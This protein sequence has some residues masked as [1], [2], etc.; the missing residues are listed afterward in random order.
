MPDIGDELIY[1]LRDYSTSEHV[2][3]IEI[4]SRKKTPRYVV[5]FLAS[6]KAGV[7]EN[8][9]RGRLR[10][11]WSDVVAYD[12][13]MANW[14]R[15]DQTEL[16][17]PEQSAVAQVFELLIPEDVAECEWSPVRDS[18]RIHKREELQALIGI[19][20]DDLLA[21]AEGFEL[22]GDVM[23]SVDG[24]LAVAE[25]ACRINPM[26]VLDWVLEDEKEH[27][28]N[29]KNGRPAVSYD[30]RAYTTSPEWEYQ[31]Y[32]EH[33][34]PVHELLR[35]WCGQRAATLQ[36]RLGAAEAENRRLD[37]LMT[38]IFDELKRLGHTQAVEHLIRTYEED[39]ITPANYRPVVDRPLKPSEIPVRYVKAPRRW[40]Y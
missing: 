23:L 12:E 8:V 28:D 21:Q 40:G 29:S 19:T 4:D 39:R 22:D 34:R 25:Y 24:T 16:T 37:E 14:E 18:T 6:D 17:D 20:V 35:S 1:R 7:Q 5:E 3:V 13:L 38:R 31:W 27:R 10:G 30:K 26:P 15:I 33:G 11:P 36:E 2:R 9:P 32:L